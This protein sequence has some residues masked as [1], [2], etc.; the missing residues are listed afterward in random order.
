M[1]NHCQSGFDLLKQ[2]L[3]VLDEPEVNPFA[4]VEDLEVEEEMPLFLIVDQDGD[5][6]LDIEL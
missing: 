2:Q 3:E 4:L 6:D 5:E 1:D